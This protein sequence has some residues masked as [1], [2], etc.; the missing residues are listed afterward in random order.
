MLDEYPIRLDGVKEPWGTPTTY[1]NYV[2]E[3]DLRAETDIYLVGLGSHWSCRVGS[4]RLAGNGAVDRLGGFSTIS[5]AV[6][7]DYPAEEVKLEG[8]VQVPSSSDAYLAL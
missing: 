8:G 7:E 6:L 4:H 3:N 1:W 2:K 5:E